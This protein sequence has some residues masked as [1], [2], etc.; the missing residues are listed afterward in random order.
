MTRSY[1]TTNRNWM[2][3]LE[4]ACHFPTDARL[5]ML[6]TLRF[7]QTASVNVNPK[8]CPWERE[9][10]PVQSKL[11]AFSGA[12]AIEGARPWKVKDG[13]ILNTE[14]VEILQGLPHL[15]RLQG[16]IGSHFLREASSFGDQQTDVLDKVGLRLVLHDPLSLVSGISNPDVLE[17]SAPGTVVVL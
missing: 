10:L 15:A 7:R 14:S 1:W 13:E 4:T 11:T 17:P 6:I 3:A 8:G 5:N 16:L 2:Q 9:G 12:S